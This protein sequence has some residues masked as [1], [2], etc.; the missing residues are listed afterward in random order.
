MNLFCVEKNKIVKIYWFF[1]LYECSIYLSRLPVYYSLQSLLFYCF[2]FFFLF[3]SLIY[4]TI[5]SIFYI[6]VDFQ[7][8]FYSVQESILLLFTCTQ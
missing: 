6:Y 8:V 2:L 5:C 7:F 4:C 1:Y 3:Y